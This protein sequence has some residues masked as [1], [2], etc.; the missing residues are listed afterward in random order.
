MDRMDRLR[1]RVTQNDASVPAI[2]TAAVVS[3]EAINETEDDKPKDE[4]GAD[5]TSSP[6][7]KEFPEDESFTLVRSED[8]KTEAT[9]LSAESTEVS[10]VAVGIPTEEEIAET[11][12]EMETEVLPA[13]TEVAVTTPEAEINEKSSSSVLPKFVAETIEMER[14]AAIISD[15]GEEAVKNIKAALTQIEQENSSKKEEIISTNGKLEELLS[16]RLLPTYHVPIEIV[17]NYEKMNACIMEQEIKIVRIGNETHISLTAKSISR[18]QSR[19]AEARNN[20]LDKI[21]EIDSEIEASELQIRN[22]KAKKQAVAQD[23][24]LL[25]TNYNFLNGLKE[26]LS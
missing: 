8:A 9:I 19:M 20:I 2:T 13:V 6:K 3:G 4:E 17:D 11:A 22:L 26:K 16:G 7:E 21:A 15:P 10:V 24:N 5:E 23:S 12:P 25:M 14:K 1:E 18:I